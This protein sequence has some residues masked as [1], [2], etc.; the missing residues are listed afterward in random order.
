[1]QVGRIKSMEPATNACI[2]LDYLALE[3]F[4]Y[5]EQDLSK[6]EACQEHCP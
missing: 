3:K 1:M 5:G 2:R 6:L 4:G